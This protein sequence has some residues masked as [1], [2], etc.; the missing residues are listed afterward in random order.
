[1]TRRSV[2]LAAICL[3][4]SVVTL[5]GGGAGVANG[6]VRIINGNP[7]TTGEFASRWPFVAA[8]V[9]ADNDNEYDGQYCGGTVISP[10]LILTAAHCASDND[11]LGQWMTNDPGSVDVLTGRLSLNDDAQ[12]QRI[13]VTDVMVHPMYD[14]IV[15]GSDVALL[16]LSEP[17]ST[18][19]ATL[20]GSGEGALWGAGAGKSTDA[21]NGPFVVG[22]GNINAFQHLGEARVFPPELRENLVPIINDATCA[23]Q[24]IDTSVSLCAGVLDT[25]PA[26]AVTNGLGVCNGDSG[27]PMTVGD[28]VGGW[29]VVGVSSYVW[30]D[31][32]MSGYFSYARVDTLRSWIE[33][34]GSGADD[35]GPG[36]LRAPV[37][38]D[39][40]SV[41]S[42]SARLTWQAPVSGPAPV[43]Y[44]VAT[45]HEGSLAT[46]QVTYAESGLAGTVEDL[47]P[48]SDYTFRVG[49]FDAENNVMYSA[50]V[51]VAT[52]PDTGNP[53]RPGRPRVD[54]V[55][56]RSARIHWH[57]AADIVGV[58]RYEVWA[59]RGRGSYRRMAL[60]VAARAS[61]HRLRPGTRYRIRVRAVDAA[62]NASSF[63]RVRVVVT[64]R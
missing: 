9:H 8:I 35:G 19:P 55:A 36:G 37:S 30:G 38:V 49:A 29:R 57:R 26:D 53:S 24:G 51:V 41:G 5:A 18:V 39:V 61:L 32:S 6:S 21:V 13:H 1:M 28:G 25:D 15:I 11:E 64:R 16:R 3:I 17:T 48:G 54:R 50:P 60:P 62:G 14:S 43:R 23:T 2:R 10:T 56:R 47:E 31:C 44:R 33:S 63:S 58:A 40:S 27:S 59:A 20:I 4:A 42:I 7:V 34:V 46:T 52:Q 22:W 12:G 45:L